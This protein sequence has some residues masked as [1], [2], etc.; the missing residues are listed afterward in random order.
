MLRFALYICDDA[1]ADSCSDRIY[2]HKYNMNVDLSMFDPD[3]WMLRCSVLVARSIHPQSVY[4]K[5]TGSHI[6]S[7]I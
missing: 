5:Q 2:E 1:S 3:S 4:V 7:E 6:D